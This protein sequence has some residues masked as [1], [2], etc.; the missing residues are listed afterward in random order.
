MI[1]DHRSVRLMSTDRQLRRLRGVLLL[2][3][4]CFLASAPPIAVKAGDAQRIQK[5]RE[6]QVGPKPDWSWLP[7]LRVLTEGD[8]PPFNYYDEEGRLSGFNID[9]ARAIC[10]E[11]SV[12]CDIN[13]AEWKTLIPSLRNGEADA[14]IASIAITGKTVAEVDF[15][16]RYY[17]TPARFVGKTGADFKDISV[18]ALKGETIAVVKGSAHEAFLRDFFDRAKI[19]PY[20]T[21]AEARAALKT[22]EVSLLFGDGVSLMFWIQGTDSARCCE[23]KGEGYTEARYF[24]DGVG[25]AVKK[26]NARLREVLDYAIA[27]V[28]ASGRFEELMLRYFPLPLY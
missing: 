7:Q 12:E 14:V 26:G 17:S 2:L 1:R 22:G 27:R 8:Y 9:L 21:P 24:G 5:W 18:D 19:A 15:T 28:K 10:R 4:L 6:A 11:L 20:D 13:A 23:F 25:I 16:S 3:A